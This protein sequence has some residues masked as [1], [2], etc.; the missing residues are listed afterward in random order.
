MTAQVASDN[1]VYIPEQW[2]R[3]GLAIL[4]AD[5]SYTPEHWAQDALVIL[6]AHMIRGEGDRND[7]VSKTQSDV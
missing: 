6:A 4:A 7:E 2:A 5:M 3:E 1:G